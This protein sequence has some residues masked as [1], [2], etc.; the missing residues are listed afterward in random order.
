MIFK[1]K[2]IINKNQ[3]KIKKKTFLKKNNL[4]I[5]HIIINNNKIR[6]KKLITVTKK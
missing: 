6:L 3:Q 4:K 2:Q 5:H 1:L